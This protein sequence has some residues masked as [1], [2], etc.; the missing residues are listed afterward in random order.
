MNHR[1]EERHLYQEW[2]AAA[3]GFTPSR[4][5]SAALLVHRRLRWSRMAVFFL[6]LAWIASAARDLLIFTAPPHLRDATH[7]SKLMI[8]SGE[9]IAHAHFGDDRWYTLSAR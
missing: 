8:K 7:S 5:K 9:T 1:H 3:T 4:L 6:V 2:Q